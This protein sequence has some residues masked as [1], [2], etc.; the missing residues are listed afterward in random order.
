MTNTHVVPSEESISQALGK[1]F[2]CSFL[3]GDGSARCY[4]RLK[5][6]DP[7][8]SFVLMVLPDEDNQLLK[9]GRYAWLSIANIL[10]SAGVPVPK[11]IK[12]LPELSA[13]VIEDYGDLMLEGFVAQASQDEIEL[14][15]IE[16]FD[17]IKKMLHIPA[18]PDSVWCHTK[19]DFNRFI[20]ELEFFQKKYLRYLSNLFWSEQDQKY[21]ET[22]SRRIAQYLDSL[23]GRFVHRDF[24]SRNIM[25][26]TNLAVIDFQDARLGPASYDLV[27]LLFDPYVTLK[28]SMRK[29]LLQKGVDYLSN[30]FPLQ[31]EEEWPAVALQRQ[32][33]AV[34]SYGYLS[35]DLKRGDYLRYVQPAFLILR[36]IIPPD[37]R[38]PFLSGELIERLIQ[39]GLPH[40]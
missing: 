13:L 26:R 9:E 2:S 35:L 39:T 18:H 24:H 8:E 33:K 1:H 7:S 25:K 38:W 19:F 32:L 6:S 22:D 30:D 12:A 15:Y 14:A 4:Y 16:C 29:S 31:I 37:S 36:D 28:I 3:A 17:I 34:G 21:F 11:L 10:Q 27:S 20:W 40:A 23:P 5:G